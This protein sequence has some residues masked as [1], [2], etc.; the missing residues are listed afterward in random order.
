M[1]FDIIKR[2]RANYTVETAVCEPVERLFE[3]AEPDIDI[4][5]RAALAR[6][7]QHFRRDVEGTYPRT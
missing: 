6:Q 1:P 3:I 5:S 4:Q 7:G 2:Q